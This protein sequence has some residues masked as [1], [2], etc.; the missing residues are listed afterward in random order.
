MRKEYKIIYLPIAYS[1]LNKIFDYICFELKAIVAAKN[2]LDK[3]DQEFLELSLFPFKGS[4]YKG[5]SEF[6]FEYRL[7][8]IENYLVFYV[9]NDDYIEIHRIIY[10]KRNLE[11]I[12]L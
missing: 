12:S 3:I 6:K 1:D 5:I 2:L 11:D 10:S 4:I 9:I 8:I 7:L